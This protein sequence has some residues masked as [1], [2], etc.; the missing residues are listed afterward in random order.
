IHL[1]GVMHLHIHSHNI[2]INPDT[3]VVKFIDFGMASRR[4][5]DAQQVMSPYGLEAPLAYLAPEQSGRMHQAIDH[6]TDLYALGVTFY[7]MLTGSVPFPS[8]DTLE[9][10]HAHLAIAPKPVYEVHP[11][12]DVRGV[13]C[14]RG[15]SL[16]A[17]RIGKYSE[18]VLHLI[19]ST[20]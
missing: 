17:Y 19:A 11:S 10:M 3:G 18:A 7:Q 1:S 4:Q 5:Q 20:L 16:T 13:L 6:R 2:V 14:G 8:H 12:I 15:R 9:V